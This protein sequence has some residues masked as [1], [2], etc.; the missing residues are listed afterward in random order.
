MQ[1]SPFALRAGAGER[2]DHGGQ[3]AEGRNGRPPGDEEC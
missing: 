2:R 1:H 3:H